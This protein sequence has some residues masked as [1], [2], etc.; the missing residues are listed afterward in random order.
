MQQQQQRTEPRHDRSQSH[1]VQY[2]TPLLI[3]PK[4]SNGANYRSPYELYSGPSHATIGAHDMSHAAS[5]TNMAHSHNI[6]SFLE[7]IGIQQQINSLMNQPSASRGFMSQTTIQAPHHSRANSDS[8]IYSITAP[9]YSPEIRHGISS[10]LSDHSPSSSSPIAL[11]SGF[12]AHRCRSCATHN[13]AETRSYPAGSFANTPSHVLVG[14]AQALQPYAQSNVISPS[15]NEAWNGLQT[16]NAPRY[17]DYI[18]YPD[19][20]YYYSGQDRQEAAMGLDNIDSISSLQPFMTQLYP[21][22]YPPL[23]SPPFSLSPSISPSLQPSLSRAPS[24]TPPTMRHIK[25]EPFVCRREPCP[26][27]PDGCG[28]RYSSMDPLRKHKRGRAKCRVCLREVLPGNMK[29]HL[30][31]NCHEDDSS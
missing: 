27:N 5:F 14:A 6:T 29:R 23:T 9:S 12:D 18:H 20:L 10:V 24:M 22:G 16:D 7:P 28:A 13:W 1:D 21:Y 2:Q 8:A 19:D 11:P 17:L 4:A 15:F 3:E 31:V 26:E 25:L 30:E